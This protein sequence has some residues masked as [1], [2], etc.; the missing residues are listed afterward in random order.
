MT[1][2]A[3]ATTLDDVG[4]RAWATAWDD[5]VLGARCPG[6]GAGERGLCGTCRRR[7]RPR[8]HLVPGDELVRAAV[9]YDATAARV[10]VAWKERGCRVVAPDLG[11]LLAASVAAVVADARAPGTFVLVP[12][13][14]TRANRRRRGRDH[15]REI[16]DHAVDTLAQVGLPTQVVPLL[17]LVRQPRDQADLSAAERRRNVAGAFA[18]R[19]ATDGGGPA[20]V[21]VDDVTTTGST[22]AA[23]ITALAGAGVPVVGAAVVAAV[24]IARRRTLAGRGPQG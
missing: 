8:P 13:P 9:P 20:A 4:G 15:V 7:L 12:V 23:G 2:D 21:L 3:V 16:A 1:S 10:L 22:L 18:V 14:T 11:R 17:R 19:R 6:C 5:L 24:E